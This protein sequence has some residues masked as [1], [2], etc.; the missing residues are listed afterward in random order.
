MAYQIESELMISINSLKQ[1]AY[2]VI[3]VSSMQD[4]RNMNWLLGDR[5]PISKS[6]S[7]VSSIFIVRLVYPE[8]YFVSLQLRRSIIQSTFMGTNLIL[9]L[10]TESTYFG[11][12]EEQDAYFREMEQRKF[13]VDIAIITA[14]VIGG[15]VFLTM[16]PFKRNIEQ[17]QILQRKEA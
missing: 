17:A 14:A 13:F 12:F 4:I 7:E 9:Y 2:Y 8:K 3:Y 1:G 6:T 11:L 16:N 10:M 5:L 15:V